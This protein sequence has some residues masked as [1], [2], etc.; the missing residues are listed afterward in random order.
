[1]K[2]GNENEGAICTACLADH[3]RYGGGGL[4]YG[5]CLRQRSVE[6]GHH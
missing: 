5:R 2:N 1:M 3:A 6:D 4:S